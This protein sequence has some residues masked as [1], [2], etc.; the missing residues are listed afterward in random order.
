M[1]FAFWR[2]KSEYN[3]VEAYNLHLDKCLRRHRQDE[4]LAY[5]LAIGSLSVE[6]FDS[7]GDLQVE[8]LRHHG[9]ADGM[10]IFDLGCGSGRTAQALQRSGWLGAYH[11]ADIIARFAERIRY[12]CPG[13]KAVTHQKPSIPMPDASVDMLYHWSVFTHI[14]VEECYLYLRDIHRVLKPGGRTVFS[15]LELN[16]PGHWRIFNPRIEY[17]EN[18]RRPPLLDVFLHRDWIA[19]F[20][21]R[22]G[23]DRPQFTAGDDGTHHPAFWQTL[24]VL[25]KPA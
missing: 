23:F 16:D 17:L 10:T 25:D 7:Q 4:D 13:Y 19:I 9:L 3:S 24:A 5:A 2:K 21:E 1:K 12:K 6:L 11:G 22:L 14:P 15:F 18:N 8:V 20:A